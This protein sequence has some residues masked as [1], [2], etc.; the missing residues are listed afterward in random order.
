M[1]YSP[2][3]VSHTLQISNINVDHPG[4]RTRVTPVMFL[5]SIRTIRAPHT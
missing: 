3:P 1:K 4:C 5:M 2:N